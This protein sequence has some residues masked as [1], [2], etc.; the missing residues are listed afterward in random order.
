MSMFDEKQRNKSRLEEEE[1][2]ESFQKLAG[3]V[4]GEKSGGDPPKSESLLLH[5]VMEDL[6]RCLNVRV[7]YSSNPEQ[8]EEWYRETVF[9]PQGIMWRTVQLEDDWYEDAIGVMLGSFADGTPV[10]LMPAGSRGCLYRDRETG[11]RIRV[12]RKNASQFRPD[13]TVYYRSFP[14][15][16]IDMGDVWD[17]VWAS[18][19]RREILTVVAAAVGVQLLSMVSPVMTKLL[20]SKVVAFR[21][22]NLLAVILF[23]LL[24]ASAAVFPA[25]R[26]S[27][28]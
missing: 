1:F 16:K 19:S 11:R 25:G 5:S 15:R 28:S 14:T 4:T 20:T 21:D 22:Q 17:F 12:T 2:I 10:V 8:T 6:G 3:V 9:R 13:A 26:S 23:V 24:F 7:P 18:L 27:A